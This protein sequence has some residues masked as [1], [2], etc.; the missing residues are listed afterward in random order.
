MANDD[1]G[2]NRKF[3]G[4]PFDNYAVNLRRWG[5]ASGDGSSTRVAI[6]T[7]RHRHTWFAKFVLGPGVTN[8]LTNAV[9]FLD[10][11]QSLYANL[12]SI[13]LPKPRLVTDTLRGS[14]RYYKIQK[15]IEYEPLTMRF[16]DDST[17]MVMGL[18]KDMIAFVNYSGE[19]GGN[20]RTS[21][22]GSIYSTEFNKFSYN[23]TGV[24]ALAG[25]SGDMIRSQMDSRPSLG[26]RMRNCSRMFF[27]SIIIY[28]LGTEPDAINIYTYRNPHL[29]SVDPDNRDQSDSGVAEVNLMFEYEDYSVSI[30]QPKNVVQA[31]IDDQ[32]QTGGS[33]AYTPSIGHAQEGMVDLGPDPTCQ[34]SCGEQGGLSVFSEGSGVTFPA[35]L[36]GTPTD[37]SNNFNRNYYGNTAATIPVSSLGLS[38]AGTNFGNSVGAA[39]QFYNGRL[40]AAQISFQQASQ[41]GSVSTAVLGY[42]QQQITVLQQQIGALQQFQ[43]ATVSGGIGVSS[44]T[45]S[46]YANTTTRLLTA[47]PDPTVAVAGQTV[48]LNTAQGV[49]D[50]QAQYQA[51]SADFLVKAE[52]ERLNVQNA[53]TPT[54]ATEA[55]KRVTFYTEQAAIMQ[56]LSQ[57]VIPDQFP[58]YNPTLYGTNGTPTGGVISAIDAQIAMDAINRY[59]TMQ[60]VDNGS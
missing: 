42:R 33:V 38:I 53:T 25:S 1:I 32:L 12:K 2:N 52:A 30:G 8:V 40:T 10:E 36:V 48:N 4:W 47:R 20:Y 35:D 56:T 44:A 28:D 41:S 50:T 23:H 34:A 37:S 31:T 13:D 17:A 59:L 27:E 21:S 19:M 24:N 22:P 18:V 11:D 7:P 29:V 46:A 16:Y 49:L 60:G 14:N 55:E 6:N 54:E 5:T 9:S 58:T 26:M 57:Y 39:L 43:N 3:G 51:A 15:K 45:T